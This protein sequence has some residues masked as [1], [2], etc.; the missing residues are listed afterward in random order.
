MPLSPPLT[1]SAPRFTR[2]AALQRAPFLALFVVIV[3]SNLAGSLFNILYNQAL[4]VDRLMD[5]DQRTAFT[6]VALPLYNAVAYPVCLGILVW[7]LAPL[8]R[9]LRMQERGQTIAPEFLERCRRRVVNLP[10]YQVTLNLLGWL[11]GAV[12]FPWVVTTWGSAHEADAITRHFRISFVV[13]AFLTTVQTFFLLEAF[14]VAV[15]YPAL[16][17][18]ARPAGMRGVAR[19]P[20]W[21]RLGG[22]WLAVGVMPLVALF[23]VAEPGPLSELALSV[24]CVGV[25]SGFVIYG[26]LCLDLSRWIGMHAAATNEVAHG[27]F[28]VRIPQKRPDEWGKLTDHFN[29]MAAALGRAKHERDTFGQ[30]FGPDVRDVILERYTGLEVSRQE[31]T[32]LFADI[33]GF[34]RRCAGEAPERIGVLLNRF[35]TLAVEAIERNGGWV[36]K[37]LG[38]GVMALFGATHPCA[39]HADQAVASAAELLARLEQLNAALI[40]DNEAPLAVGIGIHT[41]PA[42]VGCFG[43]TVA[44]GDGAVQ[45]RKELSAIGETVNLAQRIEQMTKQLGGPIL[46]SAETR[47]RL[48]RTEAVT[49]AGSHAIAGFP[50][51]LELFKIGA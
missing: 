3:A 17:R 28:E 9:C 18:D 42:L 24:L 1:P 6:N 48:Q 38:D 25:G 51:P 45:I 10:A 22:L 34:T 30:F 32:V 49:E 29:D 4:I 11:P 41:G 13:S 14:L 40:A 39:D 20:F 12:F 16:F 37:F 44:A 19:I 23:A 27:N 50:Q 43:A 33:R 5:A 7:L 35:L 36:N 2:L 15:L 31:I 21:A 47:V 46:I 26:V 8:R